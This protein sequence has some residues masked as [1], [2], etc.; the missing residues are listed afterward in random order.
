MGVDGSGRLSSAA[1]SSTR[2]TGGV[3]GGCTELPARAD[4]NMMCSLQRRD[5][6]MLTVVLQHAGKDAASYRGAT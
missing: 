6:A 2:G 4:E 3:A 5:A 1:G